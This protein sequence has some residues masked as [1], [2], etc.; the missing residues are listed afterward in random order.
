MTCFATCIMTETIERRRNG[1]PPT[2]AA[3]PH[4]QE[5]RRAL[6]VS[7][8]PAHTRGSQSTISAPP[9]SGCVAIEGKKGPMPP[10]EGEQRKN[11]TL[12][13]SKRS[14]TLEE[15]DRR[16]DELTLKSLAASSRKTAGTAERNFTAFLR[17]YDLRIG[18]RGISDRDLSRYIAYLSLT[19]TSFNTITSYLSMGA[20]RWH[21]KQ[22]LDWPKISDRFVAHSVKTGARRVMKDAISH[23]KLPITVDIMRMIRETL[24]MGSMEDVC[25]WA[26]STLSFYCLLRKGNVAAEKALSADEKDEQK[27]ESYVLKRRDITKDKEGQ[28]WAELHGSKTIQFGQRTVILPVPRIKNSSVCPAAAMD[29]YLLVTDGRPADE[30]LF[31][32]VTRLKETAASAKRQQPPKGQWKRLTYPKF[33]QK[34]KLHLGRVGVDPKKYAGHSFR[35]GGATFMHGAGISPLMIKALGDWLSS[36]FMRYCES[37]LALRVQ[38]SEAMTRATIAALEIKR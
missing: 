7:R 6:A 29:L 27:E 38:A 35:R 2:Q 14:Y 33:V 22:G 19:M 34:L 1:Y 10:A 12:H 15:I 23:Q 26:A 18:P 13:L 21:K 37:Q 25:F 32:G 24:D 9:H 11:P 4:T 31:G 28:M 20:G 5:A 36:A 17:T 30:E 16:V 8:A 3:P